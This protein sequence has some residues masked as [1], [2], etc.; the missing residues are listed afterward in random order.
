M[1]QQA[2]RVHVTVGADHV[3]R[4]P[5]EV[6]PGEAEVIVL[7]T[8]GQGSGEMA[9]KARLRAERF[10]ALRDA[11]TLAPDFDAPLPEEIL[12]EFEGAK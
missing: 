11:F 2:V 7:F 8:G 1:S 5:D 10:G 3:V 6:P 4:L 9:R 12:R